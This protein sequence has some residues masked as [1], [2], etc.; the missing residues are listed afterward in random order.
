MRSSRAWW[1]VHRAPKGCEKGQGAAISSSYPSQSARKAIREPSL[2]SHNPPA[3]PNPTPTTHT[4]VCTLSLYATWSCGRFLGPAE[5]LGS[6]WRGGRR[7]FAS[8][9]CNTLR[10]L[11]VY[12]LHHAGRAAPRLES[13]LFTLHSSITARHPRGQ[14]PQGALASSLPSLP[15]PDGVRQT[16]NFIHLIRRPHQHT[17]PRP[18]TQHPSLLLPPARA[19]SPN[20]QNPWRPRS[21]GC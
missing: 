21:I 9:S 15:T 3:A 8:S 1:G 6:G 13:R 12:P 4:C 20:S 19:R 17:T 16:H 18:N 5:D 11:F 7:A 2:S 14:A 10:F